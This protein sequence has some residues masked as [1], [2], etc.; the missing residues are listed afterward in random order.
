MILLSAPAGY[1]KSVL[2]SQW[3]KEKE[4][5][6]AWLS[7]NDSMNDTAVF[8]IYLGEALNTCSSRKREVFINLHKQYTFLSWEA[9]IEII[10]NAATELEE[11]TRLII[12]DYYLISN[13]EIHQ[14][15]EVLIREEIRNLQIIII[16]RWDPPFQLRELRLYQKMQEIRM[17][18][19]KF[20]KEEAIELLAL[21]DSISLTNDEINTVVKRTEGWILAIRMILLARSFPVEDNKIKGIENIS[22]NLDQLL[23]YISLNLEPKFF[24]QMQLCA[25]CD[26]FNVE[27]IDSICDFAYE[28]SC[29]GEVLLAKLKELNLFILATDSDG[30][31]YRFHHLVGETLIRN[32]KKTDP[33]IIIS[34]YTH[35]SEWFSDKNF[36]DEAINYAIKAENYELACSQI[37]K[38]RASILDKDQWWVLKRWLDKIP[39]QIRNANI[40]ILLTELLVCEETWNI[41]DFSS[42]LNR[43]ESIGLENSNAENISR[44]LFHLGYFLTFVEPNPKK[45]VE[46]LEQSIALF[47]DESALFGVRRESVV[48][49][50]RQ[51]LGLTALALKSLEDIHEKFER[52]SKSY[53]RS[54]DGKVLVHLLSGNFE[55]AN[56][57]LKKILFLVQDS[58]FLYLKGWSSY[59]QGNIAFQFFQKDR[60][61]N[62]FKKALEYEGI[63]NYRA[64][65]D[66]LAGLTLISSLKKDEKT[67]AS[68]LEQMGQL[69]IKLKDRKFKNYYRSVQARINWHTGQGDKELSWAT[70]DWVKQHPSSYLFLIDVPEL[71]KL[72]IVVSHGTHAQI[73]EAITVLEE[74]EAILKSVHNGYQLIDIALLKAMGFFRLQRKKRA[75]KWLEEALIQADKNEMIRPVLEATLVM[76]SLFNLIEDPSPYR[77]LTHTGLDLATRKTPGSP[78]SASNGLTLREQELVRLIAKGLRNKEIADL[79][80]ISTGTVKSHLTN[81]YSKLQVPNRISMLRKIED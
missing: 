13:P 70:A 71:T 29:K 55:S 46:A 63:F 80:N 19:L 6:N 8:L 30:G 69:A 17:A 50:S 37:I 22:N 75:V 24:R 47:H 45:A 38:H 18:D 25:L 36:V 10:V 61:M 53:V 77:I 33:D 26:Q 42:I 31:W 34:I 14:L 58:D 76:P 81:I 48:A 7:L 39:R 68:F 9:I 66:A 43:I 64:Y 2:V 54:F 41:E 3:I 20:E 57:D 32:L 73:E 67:T 78:A 74:V 65:F 79:L 16:S 40:D 59:Y 5:A 1:G 44:Y 56:N 12:D 49:C 28:G 27:L 51:M 4:G 62:A 35:I 21:D 15:V 23:S 60:A 72:R 52:S 11:K